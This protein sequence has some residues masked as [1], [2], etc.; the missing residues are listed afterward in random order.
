MDLLLERPPG[1]L[2]DYRVFVV[3]EVRWWE[4]DNKITVFLKYL[5]DTWGEQFLKHW[6]WYKERGW[7]NP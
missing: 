1:F 4:K 3:E 6:D 2:F 5:N 7:I